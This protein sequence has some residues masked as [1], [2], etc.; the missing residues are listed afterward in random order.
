MRLVD[1]SEKCPQATGRPDVYGQVID[2]QTRCVHYGTAQDIVAIKF[3]CCGR[4]F[5]CHRCHDAEANHPARTWARDERDVPAI[6]CGVCRREIT[7]AQ[8]MSVSTCPMC[9]AEFN[10]RCALHYDLY[11]DVD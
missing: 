8:Y 10:E 3:K 5:P 9:G 7:I 1:N 2:D 6:L 4:Y 11:F